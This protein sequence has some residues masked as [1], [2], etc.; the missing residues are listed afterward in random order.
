MIVADTNLLA[1]LLIPGL[2][3]AHAKSVYLRD[4]HWA[5][6]AFWRSELR[7]VLSLYVRTMDMPLNLAVRLMRQAELLIGEREFQMDSEAV[8]ATAA[9]S[10]CTAYDCEFA[11]LA[12]QLGVPLL[13]NDQRLRKAFP[14]LAVSPREYLR[15]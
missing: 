5:A 11:V 9:E 10:G 15:R 4:P 3:T 1:Y 2:F 14:A 13:T 8:L 6:P 12:R 7:N